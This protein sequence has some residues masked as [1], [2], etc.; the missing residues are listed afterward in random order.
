[1]REMARA[2]WSVEGASVP[3]G[4]R[5]TVR[6]ALRRWPGAWVRVALVV[7]ALCTVCITAAGA[8]RWG[9]P[10]PPQAPQQDHYKVLGVDARASVDEIRAAYKKLARKWCVAW[11]GVCNQ[12]AA[13]VPADTMLFA[14]LCLRVSR[15]PDKN[16]NAAEEATTRFMAINAAHEVLSDPV[17]RREYDESRRFGRGR[18][19]QHHQRWNGGSQHFHYQYSY[20]GRGGVD[21]AVS[22][23]NMLLLVALLA[24]AAFFL[25]RGDSGT[26]SEQSRPDTNRSSS[27][28]GAGPQSAGTRPSPPPP[29]P[30]SACGMAA[31]SRAPAALE[32][33]DA[34]LRQRGTIVVIF[35]LGETDSTP[36]SLWETIQNLATSYRRD[37]K[38]RVAWMQPG[39][40][41]AG[42]TDAHAAWRV[43]LQRWLGHERRPLVL[44]YSLRGSGARLAV[45]DRD[46][47]VS[48]DAVGGWVS[49]LAG[50]EVTMPKADAELPVPKRT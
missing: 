23:F 30:V 6:G 46:G 25:F 28:G 44:A 29:A 21:D 16:P 49:R 12:L 14:R 38:I 24:G 48:A 43:P 5:R 9:A 50:G 42:G 4:Q 36:A 11:P 26:G 20:N 45:L 13:H 34:V 40:A 33:S 18:P 37:P 41:T 8:A 22:P 27:S 2:Q 39:S 35:V 10:P 32:L 3:R 1:M 7:A 15:H 47:G 19:A 31:R 17:A